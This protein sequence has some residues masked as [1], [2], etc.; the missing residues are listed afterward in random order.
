MPRYDFTQ[1]ALA[2]LRDIARY[3]GS[4]WGHKQAQLYR[5]DSSSVFRSSHYRPPSVVS[6]R[7]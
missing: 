2:D 3:T 7:T 1:R 4:T 5:E 6:D